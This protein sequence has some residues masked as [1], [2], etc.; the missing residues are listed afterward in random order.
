MICCTRRERRSDSVSIRPAKRRDG[1]RVVG[2]V[3]DGLGEQPDGADGGL[4]LVATRWPRSRGGPPRRGARGCGPRRARA[5]GVE[6]SGATRTVTCRGRGAVARHQ[7]L[8]LA[9][10]AVAP[11]LGDQLGEL[12]RHQVGARDQAHRV[13][14]RAGLHHGVVGADD[15]R[16]AAQDRQHGGD[17]GGHGGLV[18]RRKAALLALAHVPREHAT[19]RHERPDER[20]EEGLR[21]RVHAMIVRSGSPATRP[22][23]GLSTSVHRP[24]TACPRLVTRR[25]YCPS[26]A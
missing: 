9:D 12:R 26:H 8:G 15:H 11:H 19:A 21:R 7:Q 16:A 10:L 3:A 5:R 6:D 20:R 13:R 17:A 22:R 24:F 1:L 18:H 25:P 4:E 23:D 2:R 14:R